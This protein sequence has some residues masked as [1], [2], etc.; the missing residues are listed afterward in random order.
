MSD[1]KA[2]I[3]FGKG[4]RLMSEAYYMRELTPFGINTRRAFRALCRAICCP[5]IILG[6]TCFVDPAMFQLCIKHLSLPGRKDFMGPNSYL[7]TYSKRPSIVN[8]VDPDDIHRNWQRV[9]RSIVDSRRLAGLQTPELDR[10]A[11]RTAASE[12]T[13]FVLTMV[14]SHKQGRTN[15]RSAQGK[16]VQPA[17]RPS[18]DGDPTGL[19]GDVEAA[20]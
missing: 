2:V 3:S 18:K 8:Q 20:D 15:G 7:K 11:I 14:P 5:T 1:D 10:T 13:R 6:S 16:A 17:N 9:V 19:H 12:L 4:V